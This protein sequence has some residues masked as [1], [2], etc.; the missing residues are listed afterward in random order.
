NPNGTIAIGTGA[1]FGNN[2]VAP[3]SSIVGHSALFRTHDTDLLKPSASYLL[4]NSSSPVTPGDVV[5]PPA[6]PG[7]PPT[8]TLHG[9][10]FSNWTVYDS[11]GAALASVGTPGDV[12][13][14][15]IN[16][17]DTT[18]TTNFATANSTAVKA[19]FTAD[20]FAHAN[21]NSGW[22]ASDWVGTSGVGG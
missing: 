5:D 15:Y 22:V 19:S 10:V 11:V 4:I 1:G 9:P 18:G 14:G 16:Y 20:Y 2:F 3:G 8:G 12:S 6:T 17:V 21:N 7:G 13:Y